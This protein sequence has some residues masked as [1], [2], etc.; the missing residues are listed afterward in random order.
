MLG[1]SRQQGAAPGRGGLARQGQGKGLTGEVQG[2][3]TGDPGRVPL[4]GTAKYLRKRVRSQMSYQTQSS[5]QSR[6][7]T[8]WD[9]G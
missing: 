5:G 2:P 3:E 8:K 6:T 7:K 1:D 9:S 4:G